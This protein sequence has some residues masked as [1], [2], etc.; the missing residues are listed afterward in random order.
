[1]SALKWIIGGLTGGLVGGLAWVLIGYYANYEV[2]YIAWGIGLLVGLGVRFMARLDDADESA[3][4][5]VVA[6]VIAFASVVGAKYV[7]FA[8]LF[9]GVAAE[10]EAEMVAST[11][12]TDDQGYIVN[13]ADELIEARMEQGE[14]IGWPA[15]MSLEEAYEEQDYPPAIWKEAEAK[16]DSLSTDEKEQKRQEQRDRLATFKDEIMGQISPSF[17]QTF[18]LFDALWLFLAVATAYKIG[19]SSDSE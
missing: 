11:D 4:Q 15:G 16:W 10:F 18:S 8:M 19:A 7:V 14:T 12:G 9:S 17:V 6:A 3:A 2:G 1:M 5:G 13:I